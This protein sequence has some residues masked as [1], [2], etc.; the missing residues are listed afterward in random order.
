MFGFRILLVTV[1]IVTTPSTSYQDNTRTD[2]AAR[3]RTT[4][5]I[6]TY[7]ILASAAACPC[8]S[9]ISGLPALALITRSGSLD[10]RRTCAGYFATLL[11]FM[12]AAVLGTSPIATEICLAAHLSQDPALVHVLTVPSELCS[13]LV[14]TLSEYPGSAW[15]VESVALPN[16]ARP[17]SR[18]S[19]L[20][21]RTDH[22]P[23]ALHRT[24]SEARTL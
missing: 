13:S 21:L 10:P 22:D 14:L 19:T 2:L 11:S 6:D 16:A 17:P 15:M 23:L 7:C 1:L 5:Q 20:A 8:T 9:N 24:D 18:T 4:E 12:Q 3:G